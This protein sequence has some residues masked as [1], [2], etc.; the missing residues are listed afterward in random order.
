[1]TKPPRITSALSWESRAGMATASVADL[2]SE[3]QEEETL[4]S[5][6]RKG[7]TRSKTVK[8]IPTAKPSGLF[9][10]KAVVEE[11]T[12]VIPV[13]RTRKAKDEPAST[14]LSHGA[15]AAKKKTVGS[16]RS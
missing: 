3:I 10:K 5:K 13:K 12:P 6:G 9:T 15:K 16:T 8:L 14:E 11:P 7:A 4:L 2:W 1:M